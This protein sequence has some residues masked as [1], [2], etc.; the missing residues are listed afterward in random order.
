MKIDDGLVR[1]AQALVETKHHREWF[2]A[3]QIYRRRNV[4]VRS[5]KCLPKCAPPVKTHNSQTRSA[6]S[7]IRKFTS[8]SCKPCR[9][10]LPN[11]ATSG[12][13]R[14]TVP[15]QFAERS[16]PRLPAQLMAIS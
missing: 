2:F 16:S 9:N 7:R 1:L 6:R 3:L 5:P 12:N 15:K 14:E 8:P 11:I 4:N 10:G 13:H